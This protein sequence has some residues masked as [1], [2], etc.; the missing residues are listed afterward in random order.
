[1]NAPILRARQLQHQPITDADRATLTARML[2]PALVQVQ[3]STI[4]AGDLPLRGIQPVDLTAVWP[5]LPL[6]RE[7]EQDFIAL[8]RS[9]LPPALIPACYSEQWESRDTR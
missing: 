3:T 4:Q 6:L 1:M 8:Y 5:P 9:R 2:A 7:V